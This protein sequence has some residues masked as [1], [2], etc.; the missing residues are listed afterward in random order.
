MATDVRL[1]NLVDRLTFMIWF[2]GFDDFIQTGLCCTVRIA[3][4]AYYS[5]VNG[6]F[7][8]HYATSRKVAGLIPDEVIGFFN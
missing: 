3:D 6:S 8:R 4:T 1:Q 5:V 7:L 2:V